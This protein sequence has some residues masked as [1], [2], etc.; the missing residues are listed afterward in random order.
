MTVPVTPNAITSLA[1]SAKIAASTAN[2]LTVTFTE[3]LT[4][5]P[6]ITPP[7][8][9]IHDKDKEKYK[10]LHRDEWAKVLGSDDFDIIEEED[11]TQIQAINDEE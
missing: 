6:T 2:N 8:G 11:T 7:H 10:K 1:Y 3:S 4:S 9:F 5:N